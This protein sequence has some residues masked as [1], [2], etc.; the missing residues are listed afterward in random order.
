MLP[1]ALSLHP[2]RNLAEEGFF[3][4]RKHFRYL[5]NLNHQTKIPSSDGGK[6]MGM[7][8]LSGR[9]Q[10]EERDYESDTLFE[11]AFTGGSS[12]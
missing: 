12:P 5:M 4:S 10:R 11:R 9:R 2:D 3:T 7:E 8:T 1:T 6:A